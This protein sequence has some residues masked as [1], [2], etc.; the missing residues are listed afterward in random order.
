MPLSGPFVTAQPT[1]GVTVVRGARMF[2]FF[3]F[4]FFMHLP[5]T[6]TSVTAKSRQIVIQ[7]NKHVILF[8]SFI[9]K[10]KKKKKTKKI[11]EVVALST[12]NSKYRKQG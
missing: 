6:G 11:I 8:I 2:F 9:K 12:V 3:F 1:H 7:L 10:E 5:C 4:F